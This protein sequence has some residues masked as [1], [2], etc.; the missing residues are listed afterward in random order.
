MVPQISHRVN[1]LFD[2]VLC[3]MGWH[4]FWAKV[5][6]RIPSRKLDARGTRQWHSHQD[7]EINSPLQDRKIEGK[8]LLSKTEDEAPRV[9]WRPKGTPLRRRR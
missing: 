5:K 4:R 8:T 3:R 6:V 1:D 2:L 9:R 7:G